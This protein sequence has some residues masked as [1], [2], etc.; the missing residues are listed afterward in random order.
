M[1]S[2]SVGNVSYKIHSKNTHKTGQE[3]AILF[4]KRLSIKSRA[5]KDSVLSSSC[6]YSVIQCNPQN[7]VSFCVL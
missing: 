4:L 1:Y 2:K 5:W 3:N 7:L 6:K